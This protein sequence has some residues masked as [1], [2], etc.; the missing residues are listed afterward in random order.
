MA[1]RRRRSGCLSRQPP[2]GHTPPSRSMPPTGAPRSW[3]SRRYRCRERASPSGAGGIKLAEMIWLSRSARERKDV[4]RG[5]KVRLCFSMLFCTAY[6]NILR[7]ARSKVSSPRRCRRPAE[8]RHILPTTPRTFFRPRHRRRRRDA[9]F[10]SKIHCVSCLHGLSSVSV[11]LSPRVFMCPAGGLSEMFGKI[12]GRMLVFQNIFTFMW[13]SIPRVNGRGGQ[14]KN[15]AGAANRADKKRGRRCGRDASKGSCGCGRHGTSKGG[16]F[17]AE[18]QKDA[19]AQ[20]TASAKAA[21]AKTAGAKTVGAK[22]AGA[23]TAGRKGLLAQRL[24]GAKTA[25]AETACEKSYSSFSGRRTPAMC[26]Q[27]SFSKE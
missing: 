24:A 15:S 23:K 18:P 13:R 8:D 26:R 9:R 21:G 6:K 3:S 27:R 14:E 20:K 22:A 17:A 19:P 25:C 11:C 5:G 1:V 12:S 16:L 10:R 2:S 4:G 7:S